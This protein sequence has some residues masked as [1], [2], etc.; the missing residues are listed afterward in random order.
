MSA[1]DIDRMLERIRNFERLIGIGGSER[2]AD[3]GACKVLWSQ[4]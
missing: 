4:R 2:R 1:D 3:K